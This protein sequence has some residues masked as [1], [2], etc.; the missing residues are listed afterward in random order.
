V[1]VQWIFLLMNFN[2]QSK[3]KEI[4]TVVRVWEI[5]RNFKVAVLTG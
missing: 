4:I 1:N 3:A 5:E 2:N